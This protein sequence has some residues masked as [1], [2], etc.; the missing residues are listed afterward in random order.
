[1]ATEN[2]YAEDVHYIDRIMHTDS[3]MMSADLHNSMPGAP[4]YL[5]DDDWMN[6]R[7]DAKPSVYQ[8]RK[9]LVSCVRDDHLP[10]Q[11]RDKQN[12]S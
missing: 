8:V 6:N 5:L 9:V 12:R 1:M 2:L 4:E 10:R 7:F 11:A 3:W